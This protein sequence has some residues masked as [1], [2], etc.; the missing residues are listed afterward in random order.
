M[1]GTVVGKGTPYLKP[2]GDLVG[3][4]VSM[5]KGRLAQ[6]YCQEMVLPNGTPPKH[7]GQRP[8]R[9]HGR[10]PDLIRLGCGFFYKKGWR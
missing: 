9:C 10:R 7:S 5:P 3:S 1:P 8:N 4:G 2:D 6:W